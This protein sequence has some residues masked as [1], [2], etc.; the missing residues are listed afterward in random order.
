MIDH[1]SQ[2]DYLQTST[3]IVTDVEF[4]FS[5]FQPLQEAYSNMSETKRSRRVAH[6]GW[7]RPTMRAN[8]GQLR[9]YARLR[10]VM[11]E[12]ETQSVTLLQSRGEALKRLQ[13]MMGV[14]DAFIKQKDSVRVWTKTAL[15]SN[16][17]TRITVEMLNAELK[18]DRTA[19]IGRI[20]DKVYDK[21]ARSGVWPI[22]KFTFF[23][24]HNVRWVLSYRS[25]EARQAFRREKAVT[26]SRGDVF[27][28]TILSTVIFGLVY[29]SRR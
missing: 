28:L 11:A 26:L 25:K 3:K 9:P 10:S 15:D 29:L 22:F 1:L 16:R 23:L 21:F 18:G 2:M 5:A 17:T 19:R 14:I 24:I 13:G 7:L 8:D 6:A 4:R 27:R 12:V 20:K